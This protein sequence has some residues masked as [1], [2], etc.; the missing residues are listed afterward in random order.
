MPF[1]IVHF[2]M[3]HPSRVVY[4]NE[5]VEAFQRITEYWP[6]IWSLFVFF[7]QNLVF[8]Q[9]IIIL[10]LWQ[11]CNSEPGQK[12]KAIVEI[13]QAEEREDPSEFIHIVVPNKVITAPQG[14][15]IHSNPQCFHLLKVPARRRR[16]F[17]VCQDCVACF[18]DIRHAAPEGEI[19][20][21]R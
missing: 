15:V 7:M 6:F 1:A 13:M 2:A 19:P 10:F 20:L 21:G 5:V 16:H 12:K 17:G 3:T 14:K 9:W 8:I 4:V 11:R 18:A